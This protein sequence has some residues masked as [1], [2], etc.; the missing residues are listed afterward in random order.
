MF[1]SIAAAI[2]FNISASVTYKYKFKTMNHLLYLKIK[3][4]SPWFTT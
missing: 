3:Q 2:Y 4:N 1:K